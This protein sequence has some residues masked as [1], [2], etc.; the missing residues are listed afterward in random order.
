MIPVVA[1]YQIAGHS[2]LRFFAIDQV[3]EYT[4]RW[5]IAQRHEQK[6][7]QC[8]FL[9]TT[10]KTT[11]TSCSTK[12]ASLGPCLAVQRM[13]RAATSLT[14]DGR[15][16]RTEAPGEARPNGRRLGGRVSIRPTSSPPQRSARP[17]RR[18]GSSRRQRWARPLAAGDWKWALSRCRC[19]CC[20]GISSCQCIWEI[21]R[22]HAA[23]RSSCAPIGQCVSLMN[24]GGRGRAWC[25]ARACGASGRSAAKLLL[26][27]LCKANVRFL[28]AANQNWRCHGG[29]ESSGEQC[30]CILRDARRAILQ[31]V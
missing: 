3:A 15:R 11:N 29:G 10:L 21:A 27:A 4:A 22:E 17:C 7:L 20:G 28:A 31:H 9:C 12:F 19:A 18:T 24:I 8:E 26:A 13:T 5:G 23:T 1:M 14:G 30:L 25:R 6:R 2:A 16:G